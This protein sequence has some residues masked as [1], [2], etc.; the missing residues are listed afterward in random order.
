MNGL[1]HLDRLES[2]SIQIIREI[3]AE[4]VRLVLLSSIGRDSSVLR[5]LAGKALLRERDA[6]PACTSIPAGTMG[7]SVSERQGRIIDL[8]G[9]AAMERMKQDGTS[10]AISA[11]VP[12]R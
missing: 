3:V 1:P 11:G 7:R 5:H 10:D 2:E 9:P 6:L 12:A 8:D 4:C